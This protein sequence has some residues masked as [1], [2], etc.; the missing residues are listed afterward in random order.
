MA[1]R[2]LG[3]ESLLQQECLFRE[4]TIVDAGTEDAVDIGTSCIGNSFVN[5]KVSGGRY[6]LTLKSGSSA[7]VL[8]NWHVMRHGDV[9]DVELGN[10]STTNPV[11]DRN[12]VFINWTSEDHEPITYCYRFGC[13]PIWLDTKVKHE[14]THADVRPD[15]DFMQ[16]IEQ[17]LGIGERDIFRKELSDAIA[18]VSYAVLLADEPSYQSAIRRY[19]FENEFKSSENIKLLGWIRS[20]SS[21]AGVHGKEQE[22]LNETVKYL[23]TQ[24]GYC[25]K[26]AFQALTITASSTSIL[27]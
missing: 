1:I 7:N 12:N 21:A 3:S 20:G 22:Q 13:K 14:V 25:G 24:L 6:V 2:F 10:W 19:V 17:N 15:E 26:C 27:D 11:C 23:M 5:F 9:V 18:S 8:E 16:A 4:F